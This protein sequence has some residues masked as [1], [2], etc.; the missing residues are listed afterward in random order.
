M[1]TGK[2]P[3]LCLFFGRAVELLTASG[4]ESPRMEARAL[5]EAVAGITLAQQLAHPEQV[6]DQGTLASLEGALNLRLRHMP[7]AQIA[8][9]AWFCGLPFRVD[10]STLIPRPETEHLVQA[11]FDLCCQLAPS[12]LPVR[13][14]DTFT[15]TGAVGLSLG[16]RLKKE[17]LA[18][19]L[20][21]LDLS[22]E[23]L[24]MAAINAAAL[25]PDQDLDL[26]RAD[27]WPQGKEVFDL[28][29]A[30]PPY[31]P[32]G[33]LGFLMPEVAQ[34][35]PVAALDGGPDGLAC[36]RRLAEEG[37]AR[38]SAGGRLILET[39]AGQADQVSLIFGAAGWQEEGRVR[40]YLGHERVLLFSALPHVK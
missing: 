1:T 7:L 35:E 3:T 20:T 37:Q 9:R 14:L 26:V 2:R 21:L 12:G 10:G 4:F 5:I 24:E 30:N 34:Y 23:A 19:D 17:G 18:F 13:I 29:L 16:A 22:E 8:G 31:I 33:E 38:L 28:I 39:G 27:I 40:D 32:A 36:Y 6:L 25:L 11:A 15:G